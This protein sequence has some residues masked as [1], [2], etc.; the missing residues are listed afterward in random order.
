[1]TVRPVSL[2]NSPAGF[3]DRHKILEKLCT[4]LIKC[5]PRAQVDKVQKLAV[6]LESRVA[7]RSNSSQSYRFNMSIL[8][9]DVMKF[10]GDLSKIVIAGKP[11]VGTSNQ[12]K[13]EHAH[14]NLSKNE[15][16]EKLKTLIL[17]KRALKANGFAIAEEDQEAAI[18]TEEKSL[19]YVLCSRCSTKFRREDVME[20]TLCKY[21]PSKKIYNRETKIHE[22]PCCGENTTS[23]SILR[24]GCQQFHF[25]V[26]RDETIENLRSNWKFIHTSDAKGD[27]NVLALDCEMAFTSLGYEMV[28]LTIVDFFTVKTVFDEFVKPLG[29]IV[30]LNSKFSGVHAKDMENALTFEAV[31]EKILTPHL[32][33]GNSILIGHGLENDLNVM[34]IVHDKVIDTAVMHSKGKFKM[35]LKNLSFELLSRKIQSGEHDS[36]EDAIASMDIVKAKIGMSLTQVDWN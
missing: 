31:M 11:L 23:T 9:R 16:M 27:V 20:K 18:E 4:T 26:F 14:L 13:R 35:S 29:K 15:V 2:A 8:L 1:M 36:S 7:R 24:L 12:S 33:N 21:H 32:I 5:K 3:H 30:D 17:D 6:E 34:R 19:E 28:R 25:H 10:R 22:Y